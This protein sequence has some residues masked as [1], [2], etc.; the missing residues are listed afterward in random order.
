MDTKKLEK[1][2]LKTITNG[3][4]S[5]GYKTTVIKCNLLVSVLLLIVLFT[6]PYSLTLTNLVDNSF[7]FTEMLLFA[8]VTCLGY[9]LIQYVLN[10][11][12]KKDLPSVKDLR[13]KDAIL[14]KDF[15]RIHLYDLIYCIIVVICGVIIHNF[16]LCSLACYLLA[17]DNPNLVLRILFLKCKEDAF[18]VY[19]P[20]QLKG[21]LVFEKID[22]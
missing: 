1:K 17:F 7:N 19:Y 5:K 14:R 13:D 3:M 2:Q 21:A 8:V 16:I 20:T 18:M 12:R 6:I 11:K 10:K 15:L 9:Y 22:Q 4:N